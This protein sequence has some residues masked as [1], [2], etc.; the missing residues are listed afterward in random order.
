MPK[1]YHRCNPSITRAEVLWFV[2]VSSNIPLLCCPY[3]PS[4]LQD[5]SVWRSWAPAHCPGYCNYGSQ[6]LQ[7]PLTPL[8]WRK[9]ATSCCRL[10]PCNATWTLIWPLKRSWTTNLRKTRLK[11]MSERIQVS[12]EYLQRWMVHSSP[13]WFAHLTPVIM[14]TVPKTWTILFFS[15]HHWFT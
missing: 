8:P 5:R 2:N 6:Q 9:P 10:K 1:S 12:Y 15:S 14:F 13:W 11:H 4:P 7:L 3:I